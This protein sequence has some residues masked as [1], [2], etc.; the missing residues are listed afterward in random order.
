M[1]RIAINGFG[2]IGR[3]VFRSGIKD[4]NIE[5]VAINDL[6]TPDNLGYLLKYDSTHGRFNGT[7]EH[8]E[9]ALIVDGKKVL[10]VSERDPEKLPWKDLKVDYVIE[11]T[12]LFTDR[13]GAEK[14]IKAGAKKV[15]ISAP[16]KDKDIPTFVM[17]VNNEKYDP[18]KDHVVSNASCTTNCLAPITKVV[19][20]NFGIEEGLMTTIHATTATQ[21]TVDGPSK[22]DWR[23]GRGA[24]QNI[25]PASTGAAKAVGLCI[26]EVNGKLTGMSFRV[27]TPDVSVV[28]LTVRT[29]KETSL[30]EI[31]AKMKE[32]S[33]GAM[34]GIL[35]YTD[36]M[37]VSNDFLSSTLSSIYDADAC[38]ELNS[39]FFKLVSW[40]DNEMGYSN[41]VLD[42]IRYM[43]K[44]G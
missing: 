44:K 40:Y 41:R 30:K 8:T 34:K 32:A 31:S 17:G 20:D 38:I 21:P 28:D 11:S 13:V 23:G 33:E 3:L 29:T 39:R 1:T 10:C 25:I 36:E 27:P 4:P 35:G 19:L 14:H 12:G 6:V 42:L 7:V 5:F 18:S 15:V 9:D 16:A 22:K 24:M 2:R 26:P 43:V 37:V